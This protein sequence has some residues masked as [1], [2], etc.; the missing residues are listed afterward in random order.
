MCVFMIHVGAHKCLWVFRVT[1]TYS[2]IPQL[3][4]TYLLETVSLR[5][6]THQ[7]GWATVWWGQESVCVHLP[8]SGVA[9]TCHT[10]M[11]VVSSCYFTFGAVGSHAHLASILPT[12]FCLQPNQYPGGSFLKTQHTSPNL[13]PWTWKLDVCSLSIA[14]TKLVRIFCESLYR[15]S[16]LPRIVLNSLSFLKELDFIPL[17]FH[18]DYHCFGPWNRK[19]NVEPE[20]C[21]ALRTNVL[22]PCLPTWVWFPGL[23]G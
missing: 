22:L 23:T 3:L 1:S 20:A 5:P 9:S 4:S 13:F 15:V 6:E 18:G 11:F 8:S 21:S 19:Q 10:L 12:E 2:I 7:F 16:P 17:N 14:L